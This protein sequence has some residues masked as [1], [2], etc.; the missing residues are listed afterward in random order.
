MIQLLVAVYILLVE[1][2]LR[3]TTLSSRV[4]FQKVGMTT[5]IKG[6]YKPMDTPVL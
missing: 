5:I 3:F 1:P 2:F 4:L 6:D